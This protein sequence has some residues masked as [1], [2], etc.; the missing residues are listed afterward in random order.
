MASSRYMVEPHEPT[1]SEEAHSRAGPRSRTSSNTGEIQRYTRAR[2]PVSN[3]GCSG[4]RGRASV[5][6]PEKGLPEKPSQGIER[7]LAR[8]PA[9]TARAAAT[10]TRLRSCARNASKWQAMSHSCPRCRASALRPTVPSTARSVACGLFFLSR[11]NRK[12]EMRVR[13]AAEARR[14]VVRGGS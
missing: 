9:G 4:P 14:L 1:S 12:T 8:S 2:R 11:G 3:P 6:G 5:P 13:A 7:A 10:A